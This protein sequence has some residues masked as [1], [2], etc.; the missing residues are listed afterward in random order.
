VV[1]EGDLMALSEEKRLTKNDIPEG[2]RK[3][4]LRR[5][6]ELLLINILVD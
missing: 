3:K 5:Q 2:I 6:K 1:I 4:I